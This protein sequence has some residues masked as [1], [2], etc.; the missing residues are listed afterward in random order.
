MKKNL[1]VT[2]I[3]FFA[4]FAGIRAQ[5][6]SSFTTTMRQRNFT[7]DADKMFYYV[8]DPEDEKETISPKALKGFSKTYKNVTG[9][10]WSKVLD[11]FSARFNLDGVRTTIFYDNKGRWLGSLKYYTEDKMTAEMKGIVKRSYY[12]YNIVYVQEVEMVSSNG[13]PTYIICVEDKDTIK[14]IRIFDGEMEVWKEFTR[15]N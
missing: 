1:I 14:D 8:N 5:T 4:S 15:A 13:Q 9:E 10:S 11:G 12:N 7:I 6:L 3:V 2:V